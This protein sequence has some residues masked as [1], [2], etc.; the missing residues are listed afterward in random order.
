MKILAKYMSIYSPYM[1]KAPINRLGN[2]NMYFFRTSSIFKR[3]WKRMI[4][5]KS[6]WK[7]M[8]FGFIN[9]SQTCVFPP[10]WTEHQIAVFTEA[11]F[12]FTA[13]PLLTIQ[14]ETS[15]PIHKQ[16]TLMSRFYLVHQAT[17]T[18]QM[19]LLNR[20]FLVNQKHY[21]IRRGG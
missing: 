10:M 8:R 18:E 17:T 5:K 20:F 19:T 9:G 2:K 14:H 6:Y 3:Y 13:K 11:L 15:R 1:Y 12:R 4:S 21:D 7:R 16:T